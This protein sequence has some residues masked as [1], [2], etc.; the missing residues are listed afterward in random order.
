MAQYCADFIIQRGG[1]RLMDDFQ[2]VDKRINVYSTKAL[3]PA[4]SNLF[5]EDISVESSDFIQISLN[6]L[7]PNILKS[8]TIYKIL[9][10]KGYLE[11]LF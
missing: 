3:T 7:V 11:S 10:I 6:R 9:L 4:Q 2:N 5:H 1:K 8:K